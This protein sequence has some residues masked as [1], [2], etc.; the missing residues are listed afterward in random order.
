MNVMEVVQR[1]LPQARLQARPLAHPLAHPRPPFSAPALPPAIRVFVVCSSAMFRRGVAAVVASEPAFTW[2]GEAAD[3]DQAVQTAAALEPD[4]VLI[5]MDLQPI[6]GIAL[7]QA[8]RPLLPRARFALMVG[9]LDTADVRRAVVSGASCVLTESATRWEMITA[10]QA[11]HLGA[12]VH[13]PA[14]I[15]AMAAARLAPIP[16]ER[17]T[18]RERDLLTW[19]A[20]GLS[21][22]DIARQLTIALPT[23]KFHITNILAKLGAEN[24]TT[25]VLTALRHKLVDV[26]GLRTQH[27]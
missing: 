1:D 17:L 25:A 24:R 4:V 15:E 21:N 20:R 27:G 23:V 8:L 9:R 11:A 6:D 19:M 2:V 16:D 13:S 18:P 3:A 22:Q 14:V 5:E 12:Q 26:D 7:M 10:M